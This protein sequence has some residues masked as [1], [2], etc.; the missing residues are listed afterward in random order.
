MP[1]E[2]P[3]ATLSRQLNDAR[4]AR[5]AAVE[6]GGGLAGRRGAGCSIRVRTDEYGEESR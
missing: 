4:R 3:M 6:A 5:L 2:P 1:R